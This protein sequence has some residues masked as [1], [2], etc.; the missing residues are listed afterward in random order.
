[1]RVAASVF[2]SVFIADTSMTTA[3]D[4]GA[5]RPGTLPPGMI[6][7]RNTVLF[8]LL[9]WLMMA[10]VAPMAL[11][12]GDDGFAMSMIIGVWSYGPLALLCFFAARAL[13]VR[14]RKRAAMVAVAIP[15]SIVAA[16]LLAMFVT[17]VV[18]D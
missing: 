10:M 4:A 11:D 16:L 7:A 15:L 14:E 2:P 12:S 3:I 13:W 1:M 6:L 17:L 8:T 5:S 18:L 9:P